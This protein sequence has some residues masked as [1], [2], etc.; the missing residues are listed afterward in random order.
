[1]CLQL[2]S[3]FL[4]AD[5]P[6]P[7]FLSVPWDTPPCNAAANPPPAALVCHVHACVHDGMLQVVLYHQSEIQCLI[8][9]LVQGDFEFCVAYEWACN[10]TSL[11]C[12]AASI[13][14]LHGLQS[15][16]SRE[17]PGTVFV[18]LHN[19]KLHPKERNMQSSSDPCQVMN[20][21][22]PHL[23]PL[24]LPGDAQSLRNAL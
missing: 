24:F 9:L 3:R 19:R 8:K 18:D 20:T 23:T 22:A 17:A 13:N 7:S 1:M 14:C 12:V 5:H 4:Y 15:R 11:W 6:S 10:G 21:G 2:P 16:L